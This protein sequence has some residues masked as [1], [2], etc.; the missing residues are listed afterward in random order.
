MYQ[1]YLNIAG[2]IP[3][4]TPAQRLR[5]VVQALFSPSGNDSQ[6]GILHRRACAVPDVVL[7]ETHVALQVLDDTRIALP[8]RCLDAV[9]LD[10]DDRIWKHGDIVIP[11]FLP[12]RGRFPFRQQPLL[13]CRYSIREC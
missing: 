10:D 13:T 5:R 11:L 4:Y 9:L 1:R 12:R 2:D 7:Q 3:T 8:I 6:T